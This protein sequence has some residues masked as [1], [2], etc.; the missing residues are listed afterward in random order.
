MHGSIQYSTLHR[1]FAQ[2]YMQVAHSPPSLDNMLRVI[3]INVAGKEKISIAG[4]NVCMHKHYL[5]SHYV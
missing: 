2:W 4:R 5:F 1:V 3:I